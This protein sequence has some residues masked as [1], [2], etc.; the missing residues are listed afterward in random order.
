MLK[1]SKIM[2]AALIMFFLTSCGGGGSPAPSQ[3]PLLYNLGVDFS[4]FDFA[5]LQADGNR[6]PYI[7]FGAPFRD[8]FLNATFEYYLN[9]GSTIVSPVN[10]IVIEL[11][12]RETPGDYTMSLQASNAS[13]WKIIIDHVQQPTIVVG[14]AVEAGQALGVAGVWEKTFGRTELQIFN[15]NDN[16]SYCPTAFLSPDVEAAVKEDLTDLMTSWMDYIDD[17]SAYDINA[18]NPVGCLATTVQG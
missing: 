12:Y 2:F 13:D 15:N 6:N 5:A 16:L 10:G 3:R 11:E 1:K 7:A 18:M 4:D 14:D 17:Q 8:S 9:A